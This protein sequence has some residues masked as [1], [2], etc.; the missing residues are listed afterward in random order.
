ME[1]LTIDVLNLL[2]SFLVAL[3]SVQIDSRML[4]LNGKPEAC[5][6]VSQAE[7]LILQFIL[8][9]TSHTR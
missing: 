6:D 2:N 3:N 4:M 9:I 7:I 5:I 1:T 8:Y